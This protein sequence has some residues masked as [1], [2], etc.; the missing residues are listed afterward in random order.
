M[1]SL[2]KGFVLNSL[3]WGEPFVL[4]SLFFGGGLMK[5]PF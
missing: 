2:F 4:N 1:N 3:F 5:N